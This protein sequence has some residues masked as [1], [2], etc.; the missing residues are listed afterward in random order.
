MSIVAYIENQRKYSQVSL[1]D[2]IVAVLL[3]E[4]ST[5]SSASLV[6][7]TNPLHTT[8][9]AD[10]VAEYRK[11]AKKVLEALGLSGLWPEEAARLEKVGRRLKE[12]SFEEEQDVLLVQTPAQDYAQ[13]IFPP[14]DCTA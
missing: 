10:P 13:V 11:T 6:P 4:S 8:F 7:V 3:L 9:P 12:G 1:Q 5:S 14:L 2:A